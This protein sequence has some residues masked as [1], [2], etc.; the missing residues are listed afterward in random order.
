MGT[1]P[2]VEILSRRMGWHIEGRMLKRRVKASKH[3]LRLPEPSWAFDANVYAMLRRDFDTVEVADVESGLTYRIGA[4]HFDQKASRTD[5]GHGVQLLV[6]L[7]HWTAAR[8][9]GSQLPL[10]AGVPA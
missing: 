5:R 7:R 2:L 10:F 3:L 6:P 8:R 1:A 4:A 9:E